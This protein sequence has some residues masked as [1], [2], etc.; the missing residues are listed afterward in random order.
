[1]VGGWMENVISACDLNKDTLCRPCSFGVWRM[2][3]HPGE[4]RR[5]RETGGRSRSSAT[6]PFSTKEHFEIAAVTKC[7]DWDCSDSIWRLLQHVELFSNGLSPFRES[8][9]SAIEM[10]VINQTKWSQRTERCDAQTMNALNLS[11]WSNYINLRQNPHSS[12][13]RVTPCIWW[14]FHFQQIPQF[15]FCQPNSYK[16]NI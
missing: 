4:T 6:K 8:R 2:K 14:I 11:S 1:M 9:G 16:L 5:E 15:K 12:S 10:A 7:S 3:S 13:F